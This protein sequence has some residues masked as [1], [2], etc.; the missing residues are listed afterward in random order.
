MA[1][2]STTYMGLALQ[3]PLLLASS[4]IS[5]RVENFQMAEACGVG[6]VVLRSLFEEQIEAIDTALQEDLARAAESN[7]EARTYF[8]PQRIGPHD[9]LRLVER[10]KRAVKV[11]VIASLNCAAPGSW[12]EYAR[13]IQEA[14]ADALEVNVYSVAADP[15]VTGEQIERN[16]LQVIASVREAVRIPTALKLSPFFTSFANVAAR[17]EAAGVNALVL[18]NRFLQPDIDL[19]RLAL[20]SSMQ[21]SHPSEML[22]P[23]RWIALLYSRVK[24]DLAASTGVHDTAGVV[25]QLLAGATVVQLASTLVKNGVPHLAVLRDG[26][27]DWMDRGGYQRV[28]DFKGALS[29]RGVRDPCAFERAQYVHLILS[30]NT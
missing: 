3:S 1:D 30:Q 12:S 28:E 29:Q 4:S 18:F 2:L 21:L 22:L 6:A 9:Y 23:L 5:N 26:L 13:Q 8:P 10:A 17:F 25:K 24:V 19:D 20:Q 11:P 27:E 14:G 16:Y 7:P 15:S